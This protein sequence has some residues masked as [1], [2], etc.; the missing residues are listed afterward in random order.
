RPWL[1]I[2]NRPYMVTIGGFWQTMSAVIWATTMRLIPQAI[3]YQP[4][5]RAQGSSVAIAEGMGVGVC[6]VAVR[7]GLQ[8]EMAATQQR[9]CSNELA[10]GQVLGGEVGA[11][12]SVELIEEREVRAG[13]LHVDQIVHGHASLLEGGLDLVEQNLDFVVDF[14]RRLARLVQADAP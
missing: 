4:G 7:D 14:G 8:L 12:D 5:E 13:D 11:V 6:L 9:G 2:P 10:R 3:K 1:T